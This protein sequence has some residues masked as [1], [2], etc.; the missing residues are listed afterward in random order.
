MNYYQGIFF[1]LLSIF[2]GALNDILAKYLCS[3]LHATQ[4]SF[5]RF[6]FSFLTLIPVLFFYGKSS[7]VTQNFKVHIYR[8]LLL[9]LGMLTWIFGLN[10]VKISTATVMS[11]SI[12]IFTLCFGAIFL[13]EKIIWQRWLVAILGFIG[14][15][16]TLGSTS[17]DFNI[18]S[19]IFILSA[20]I[21]ACLDI[22]NKIYI[23]K[24]VFLV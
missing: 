19:L 7:L 1:F 11:F 17:D 8:S 14:I 22:I 3:N 20:C 10:Y 2:C 13:K 6:L 18:M 21:F 5:L 12:P 4:I 16:I 23:S 24:E 9:F 15:F